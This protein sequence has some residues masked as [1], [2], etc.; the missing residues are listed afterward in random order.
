MSESNLENEAA[1]VNDRRRFDPDGNPRPEAEEVAP[2][3]AAAPAPAP[4]PEAVE[5]LKVQ[6]ELQAAR[7]RVDELARGYQSL[8]Q[9]R[10]DF[11]KRL[12]RERDGLMDVE[13]GKVV[14]LLLEAIDELDLC[15]QAAGS[16]TS[17]LATGVRLIRDKLLTQVAGQGVERLKIVGL[18][19]DP[20]WAEAADMEM[21]TNP[22]EDQRVTAELRAGYKLKDRVLRPAR[23]RVAKYVQP[24]SA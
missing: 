5:L 13:R 22:D 18:R 3:Q 21:T 12:S 2:E 6:E 14:T 16:D 24:A 8:Q 10:E 20:N 11:K 9:D 7:K 17:A 19:F 23:V 1:R 15:L 4:S